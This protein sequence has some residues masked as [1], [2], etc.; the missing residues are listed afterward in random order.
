MSDEP[1]VEAPPSPPSTQP[2]RSIAEVSLETRLVIDRLGKA[3]PDEVVSYTELS[4]LVGRDIRYAG[5]V[6][7]DTARRY[8][9]REGRCFGVVRTVGVKWLP[10]VELPGEGPRAATRMRR[11]ARRALRKLTCF[12][13][14]DELPV[15][16]Q[17][18]VIAY[19]STFGAVELVT[20]V[21]S[22]KKLEAKIGE[23]MECLP[24]T[25]TL[26]LFAGDHKQ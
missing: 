9:E 13:S 16:A 1:V 14:F 19:Q 12:E 23:T 7:L 26:S 8:W 5:R 18:Q 24:A 6:N 10:D 17:R 4:A 3:K 20:K 11:I 25:K 22:T 21:S 15:D 2:K